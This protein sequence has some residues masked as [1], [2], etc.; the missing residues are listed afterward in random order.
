M[1][2]R[3]I[4]SIAEKKNPTVVGL[5]PTLEMMP[6]QLTDKYMKP[7]L[8][9][10]TT[11]VSDMFLEFN[12]AIIDA[13]SPV[14]A[15]VKPQIAMYEKYG[16]PGL[17]TYIETCKYASERGMVVIGDIKRGDISST[18]ACYAAHIGGIK[19]DSGIID[20]WY[21]D[22][23][24][25]N[26][27]MG[28]DGIKP[29]LNECKER[30]KGIF[31]LLKTSNPSSSELQ[32]LILQDGRKVYELMGELIADWGSDLI[33]KHGYSEVGA[34]VGATHREQG[35][36]LREALPHTFFLVPGYGAQGAT[37]ED[38]AGFF[39]SKGY[40][41][42]ISS[43]R[44]ITAAWKKYGDGHEPKYADCALE[45]AERMRDEISEFNKL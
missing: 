8:S 26:P 9:D 39:D 12:M 2:D 40:G 27:Y 22:A 17:K 5:D 35:E 30:S 31:V 43:S 28:F 29:F 36:A 21:E 1:I 25:L 13:I 45:A 7:N 20:T 16:L 34:V 6:K 14:V 18:A 15:A 32:D 4:E 10:L 33:G 41:A 44:G 11:A 42:V 24:T 38:V 19:T 3:L 23:V 37:A